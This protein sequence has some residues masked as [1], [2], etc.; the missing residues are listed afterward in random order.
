MKIKESLFLVT[1]APLAGLFTAAE[2]SPLVSIGD[3]VDVFFNGSSSLKWESNVFNDEDDEKSDLKWT[4]SPGFE[5]NVG[6]GVSNLDLSIITRYDIIRYDDLSRLDSELFHIKAISS[7]QSS[8][9]DVNGLVSFD[10]SQSTNNGNDNRKGK[11]T[12][13]DN[14]AARLNGEYRLSPKF[15]VGSGVNYSDRE[16]T[17]NDDSLAD[18][19]SFTIPL[20]VYYELTPKVD[21]SVGYQYT[22]TDV[23]STTNGNTYIGS[24]DSDSHFFNVGARGNLLPKLTGFFK[25]GYTTYD[26]DDSTI[27]VGGVPSGSTDRD[28]SG[29]MGFDADFTYLATPKVTTKLHLHRGFGIGGEGQSTEN[30]TANLSASYSINTN[31]SASANF[32]YT[33]RDYTDQNR[34]DNYYNT[35]VRLSYVP[36][37]YWRFSTGYRY[38]ENDSD[39]KG[40]S[41]ESH[42]IDLTASLR[43]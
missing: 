27:R 2:A 13:S 38:S 39:R 36:N 1:L 14:T 3:N 17:G 8:R 6:R 37:Q 26:P 20:D 33:F 7:Y 25:V 43:Y 22:T 16:Y 34:E 10:E 40:Q 24:Y 32:G 31:Y 18:R 4:V 29:T 11:I 41:Y 21:L 5:V 30:T 9:W 42:T 15:S 28:S 23:G 19:E 35:G 12:E